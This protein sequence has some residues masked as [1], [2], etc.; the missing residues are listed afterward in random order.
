MTG[1]GGGRV[2][3]TRRGWV[4]AEGSGLEAGAEGVGPGGG[5]AKS[6]GREVGE[7]DGGDVDIAVLAVE[8]GWGELIPL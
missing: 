8:A 4:G 1:Q 7:D 5:D 2:R 3:V 6:S